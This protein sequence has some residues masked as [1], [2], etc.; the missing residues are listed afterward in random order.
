MDYFPHFV[1][2]GKTLFTI[3]QKY[4]NDGY[5]FWF[6][7]L[8]L[9][10]STENHFYDCRDVNAWEFL[11]AKT[12]LD[13]VSASEILDML[14]K[15]G[16]I[17]AELWEHRVI[18]SANFVGNLTDVYKKRVVS[19]PT[20][21]Q[22]LSFR[23]GNPSSDGISGDINPQSKVKESKGEERREISPPSKFNKSPWEETTDILTDEWVALYSTRPDPDFIKDIRKRV[24][25]SVSNGQPRAAIA[26]ALKRIFDGDHILGF[27]RYVTEATQGRISPH[28][29][30]LRE[31]AYK[32][33]KE[34]AEVKCA[35]Q[36]KRAL[37]FDYCKACERG[38]DLEMS[39]A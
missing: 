30:G 39:K 7:L 9:L 4:G 27:G 8:E 10:G 14:A 28:D 25:Q 37:Y 34:F 13:E 31:K 32:C 38:Q 2:H 15:L 16:A 20:K 3:E 26:T 11:L 21:A 18:W 22:I 36:A 33:L 17:D 6:K 12:R 1:N 23:V 29:N 19:V 24:F 35:T 5:A